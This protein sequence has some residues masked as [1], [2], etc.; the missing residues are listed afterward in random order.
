MVNLSP[1]ND[2]DI[3]WCARNQKHTKQCRYPHLH[4]RSFK[5]D[6][7]KFTFSKNLQLILVCQVK[8]RIQPT[9]FNITS[10]KCAPNSCIVT[11]K[12]KTFTFYRDTRR[13]RENN[14]FPLQEPHI[15][16][17]CTFFRNT[18]VGDD[19]ATA[20]LLNQ[21]GQMPLLTQ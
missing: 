13:G 20:M 1:V 5:C 14:T 12:S 17:T 19:R 10:G 11:D 21:Y 6:S 16:N 7:F 18:T 9:W 4:Q 2:H 15:R 8:H 3:I